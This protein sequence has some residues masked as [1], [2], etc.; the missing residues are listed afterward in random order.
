MFLLHFNFFVIHL[1]GS[2]I[3]GSANL[4]IHR[5]AHASFL[6]Y[7]LIVTSKYTSFQSFEYTIQ[8]AASNLSWFFLY[9]SFHPLDFLQNF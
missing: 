1:D 8:E 7:R 5:K 3:F 2:I 9:I 4:S 6:R